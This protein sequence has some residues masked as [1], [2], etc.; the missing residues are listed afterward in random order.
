[1]DLALGLRP[2]SGWAIAVVVAAPPEPELVWRARVEVLGRGDPKQ[3]WHEAQYRALDPVAAD[4]LAARVA[5]GARLAADRVVATAVDLGVVAVGIV[6]A[7]RELPPAD[8][9]L[10]NHSLLHA[11]EGELYRAALAD[12]AEATGLP[13]TCAAA[14][15]LDDDLDAHADALAELRREHGAPWQA[16]HKLAAV[17]AWAA[18]AE[19][20]PRRR[21]AA[22]TQ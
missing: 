11:A 4:A 7:P 20:R 21:R 13:V 5:V 10:T 14:K 15:D 22:K 17:A 12:A 16:D 9:I 3:P 2:H 6:G 18:L 19:A 8:R 1:V